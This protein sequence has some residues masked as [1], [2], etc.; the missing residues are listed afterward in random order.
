LVW[1]ESPAPVKGSLSRLARSTIA[2]VPFP[3]A[4]E[5]KMAMFSGLAILVAA[6]HTVIASST[7]AGY[8][9]FG[10]RQLRFCGGIVAA[11]RFWI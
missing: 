11:I 1:N 6:F 8:R 9:W 2:S 5:P 3:P 7:P 4:E 10:G